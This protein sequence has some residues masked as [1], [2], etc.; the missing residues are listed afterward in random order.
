[1]PSYCHQDCHYFYRTAL[2]LLSIPTLLSVIYAYSF[3]TAMTS[4]TAIRHFFPKSIDETLSRARSEDEREGRPGS[5]ASTDGTTTPR[6]KRVREVKEV[7]MSSKKE[8]PKQGVTFAGQDKLPKLPI[9]DL[10]ST[11]KKYL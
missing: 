7:S 3:L 9:P 8:S 2:R 6:P 4:T 5:P 10:D 11:L 1:M